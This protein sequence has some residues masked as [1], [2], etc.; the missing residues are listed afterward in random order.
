MTLWRTKMVK[1]FQKFG[2]F[3]AKTNTKLEAWKTFR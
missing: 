2:S 3:A 1:W